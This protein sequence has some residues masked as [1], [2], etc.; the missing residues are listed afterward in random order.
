MT[1]RPA[2]ILRR[3]RLL[4]VLA[5]SGALV[6][7]ATAAAPGWSPYVVHSGDTLW[8]LARSRHTTV[9]ALQTANGVTGDLIRIGQVL[10]VP[11]NGATGAAGATGVTASSP[12]S[13]LVRAGD[14]LTQI[15]RA[16]GTSADA[17]A[18]RN[19]CSA[20][21]TIYVGQR[22]TL[23]ARSTG[24]MVGGV[25]VAPAQAPRYQAA[26]AASATKVARYANPGAH[27]I[28][29]LIAAE[30]RRQ[31]V[32]VPLA[33]AVA[34]QESGFS[35]HVVSATNAV[36]VMQLMPTT[37]TWI[38][39]YTGRSLDRYNANDNIRG[40]VTLLKVLLSQA[41]LDDSVAGYYQ[42]LASV[43]AHGQYTDTHAY[44]ANVKALRARFA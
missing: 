9:A 25:F 44:V 16:H 32:P 13:Y 14:T 38:E 24:S 36:G 28:R 20:A 37:A 33:E 15:A 18:R 27:Q 41:S 3:P 29:E 5:A 31:G 12:P 21:A 30:A 26:I 34:Y 4:R 39:Q 43:R 22:L 11:G 23:P 19:H 17:I 1:K 8:G 6:A 42:G 10:Q 35:Q 2:P 7:L 40:G